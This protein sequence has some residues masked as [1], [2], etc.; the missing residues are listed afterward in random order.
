MKLQGLEVFCTVDC[1]RCSN[2]LLVCWLVNP[3]VVTL[4]YIIPKVYVI[5]TKRDDATSSQKAE[6]HCDPS[7]LKAL[8]PPLP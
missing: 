5:Y 3:V 2:E 1:S 6:S 7:Y 8:R 4:Q